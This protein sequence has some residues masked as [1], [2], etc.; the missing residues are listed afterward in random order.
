MRQPL[1]EALAAVLPK[2]KFW[3]HAWS[4]IDG[5]TPVSP[6][7]NRCWL[8]GLEYRMHT[9]G[10]ERD[11]GLVCTSGVFNA[12]IIE[13]HD[14]ID[15]PLKKHRKPRVYAIWSDLFHGKVSR[16]FQEKAFSRMA[17]K[18]DDWFIII[19]KR[20]SVAL[21]FLRDWNVTTPLENVIILVTAEDQ[22]RADE[23]MPYAL[24]ISS[25]DWT[26]GV[27]CEPLLGPVDLSHYLWFDGSNGPEGSEERGWS[28]DEY[29]GGLTDKGDDP[30][31]DPKCGLD[32]IIVGGETGP[33]ARAVEANWIKAL[34]NQAE[35]ASTPFLFKSWGTTRPKFTVIDNL[36]GCK[37]PRL[38]KGVEYLEVP[39]CE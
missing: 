33:G 2:G 38:L 36:N 22:K 30:T 32:W 23:R 3:T 17:V 12:N 11:R 31:Y 35:Y 27:L 14:R 39:T 13:R 26:V 37:Q 4:I 10:T 25:M 28:Y 24:S 5:C 8:A 9:P 19:T 21:T 6:G 16:D 34:K 15:L 20:P 18:Q 1:S 29:S 7:C